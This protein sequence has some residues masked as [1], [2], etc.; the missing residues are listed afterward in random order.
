MPARCLCQ[1]QREILYWLMYASVTE[2]V[3]ISDRNKRPVFLLFISKFFYL[4]WR[5]GSRGL[6]GE[7]KGEDKIIIATHCIHSNTFHYH[8]SLKKIILF[9]SYHHIQF[10]AH[11]PAEHRLYSH[12]HQRVWRCRCSCCISAF[13]LELGAEQT[14]MNNSDRQMCSVQVQSKGQCGCTFLLGDHQ[15]NTCAILPGSIFWHHEVLLSKPY[16]KCSI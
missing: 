12:Y 5:C 4:F 14:E 15:Q 1:S 11:S 13:D 9:P 10:M 16:Q 7:N 2:T 8:L 6:R 3:Q